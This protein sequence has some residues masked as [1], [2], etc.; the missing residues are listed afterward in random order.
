MEIHDVC[1][2]NRKHHDDKSRVSRDRYVGRRI[3]CIDI[4]VA[5]NS[6]RGGTHVYKSS[7]FVHTLHPTDISLVLLF[8]CFLDSL[9]AVHV[10]AYHN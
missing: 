2:N 5:M 3:G 6:T 7:V 9:P 10:I 1:D 8:G 4:A